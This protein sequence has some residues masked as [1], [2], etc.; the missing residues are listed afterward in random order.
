MS[1][2]EVVHSIPLNNLDLEKRAQNFEKDFE[3][4][5]TGDNSDKQSRL[6]SVITTKNVAERFIDE[7]LTLQPDEQFELF[8]RVQQLNDLAVC[9]NKPYNLP[10]I[11]IVFGNLDHDGR[12]DRLAKFDLTQRPIDIPGKP[13]IQELYAP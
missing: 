9:Q 8:K 11:N 5:Y 3:H 10:V 12:R 4:A 13:F 6:E 1:C 7:T 2:E